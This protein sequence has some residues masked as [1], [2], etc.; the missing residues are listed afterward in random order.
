[1]S[2]LFDFLVDSDSGWLFLVTRV[3]MTI[4][5]LKCNQLPAMVIFL[6]IYVREMCM[7]CDQKDFPG[8]S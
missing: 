2:F 6:P 1:M 4:E 7:L 3:I 8:D 5:R